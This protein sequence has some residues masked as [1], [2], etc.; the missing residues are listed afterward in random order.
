ML[1]EVITYNVTTYEAGYG[2]LVDIVDEWDESIGENL[3]MAWLY[4]K[5]MGVKSSV[6]GRP[7]SQVHTIAEFIEIIE[8]MLLE[9]YKMYDDAYCQED[10]VDRGYL[11][12]LY[13][14]ENIE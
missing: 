8:D 1:K 4:R 14:Q 11:A 13:S 5:N 10:D 3:W 9:E 6:E 7:R 12:E 2:F